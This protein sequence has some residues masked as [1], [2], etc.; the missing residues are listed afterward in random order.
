MIEIE[1]VEQSF[2]FELVD[3]V[4]LLQVKTRDVSGTVRNLTISAEAVHDLADKLRDAQ[5]HLIGRLTST[6]N[7]PALKLTSGP[8][9]GEVY[10]PEAEL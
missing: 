4:M 3:D 8:T 6:G 2:T 10:S 1:F 9:R 7:H 5:T